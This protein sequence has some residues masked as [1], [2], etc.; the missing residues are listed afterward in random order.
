M[1]IR[2]PDEA[3]STAV[4]QAEGLDIEL[5][6]P[7]DEGK[8]GTTNAVAAVI[9]SPGARARAPKVYEGLADKF[10]TG[11][12]SHFRQEKDRRVREK[13]ESS[14]MKSDFTDWSKVKKSTKEDY[15]LFAEFSKGWS[16]PRTIPPET[17]PEGERTTTSKEAIRPERRPL[18]SVS[19]DLDF[20]TRQRLKD[21]KRNH[22]EPPESDASSGEK[23][24]FSRL[25][26]MSEALDEVPIRE[27][28]VS[29]F[30]WK[31]SKV[32]DKV[33]KLVTESSQLKAFEECVVT[34]VK[35]IATQVSHLGNKHNNRASAAKITKFRINAALTSVESEVKK[36]HTRLDSLFNSYGDVR[37]RF[38]KKV[39]WVCQPWATEAK[40]LKKRVALLD[41]AVNQ[42]RGA[43]KGTIDRLHQLETALAKDCE[44]NEELV[45][46]AI[47]DFSKGLETLL[48]SRD[49]HFTEILESQRVDFQ[50]QLDRYAGLMD[51]YNKATLAISPKQLKCLSGRGKPSD[52]SAS[53]E[54]EGRTRWGEQ[55]SRRMMVSEPVTISAVEEAAVG[56]M[57][58]VIPPSMVSS[59][60]IRL[61]TSNACYTR[62]LIIGSGADPGGADGRRGGYGI[63][64]D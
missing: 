59:L 27:R 18:M 52:S 28:S 42:C 25:G 30:T 36:L 38:D 15:A 40:G 21:R 51:A 64:P 63:S 34:V 26:R 17:I 10:L 56:T 47:Q 53:S 44:D 7:E 19:V 20:P 58:E 22:P 46:A 13:R 54:E 37:E 9:F 55:R 50:R 8:K 16:S 41:T 61:F 31:S 2:T 14:F 35:E 60:L 57:T 11:P 12:E 48:E 23:S 39:E 1:D 43:T 32:M 24:V 3:V 49:D 6:E 4:I 29:P 45:Q 33:P 5:S 62:Y